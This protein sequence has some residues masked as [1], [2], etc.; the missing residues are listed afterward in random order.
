M[1]GFI[2]GDSHRRRIHKNAPWIADIIPEYAHCRNFIK[3]LFINNP[4]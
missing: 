4:N 3:G 2:N 1:E